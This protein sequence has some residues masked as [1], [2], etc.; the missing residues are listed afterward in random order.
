MVVTS[1]QTN[2]PLERAVGLFATHQAAEQAMYRLR[3]TGFNM[4]QISIVARSGDGLR[5]ITG[6][7]TTV[8]PE[9]IT[10]EAQEGAGAGA[11]TGAIAGG[12]IGLIGS[13]GILA[14]PGV[15]LVA[16]AGFLLGNALLGSGIGA[17]S[18]GLIGALA[19]W[20]IPEDRATYYNDRVYKEN[21]YLV[22]LEGTQSEI[23]KAEAVLREGGIRDW[24]TYPSTV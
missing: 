17:A 1:A 13:L 19:G 10:Q 4:D 8:P 15:G 11:T 14:I 23:R 20:G 16:E 3:D 9:S 21:E 7:G 24:G 12:T 22:L 18:G 6:D 2:T 5:D